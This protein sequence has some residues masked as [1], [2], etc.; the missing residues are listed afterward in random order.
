[1]TASTNAKT[2]P[3]P[4]S[5]VSRLLWDIWNT[6][7]LQLMIIPGLIY[8]I[9][10]KYIPIYG[11][12]IAFKDYKVVRG[13]AG[14]PWVGFK[15]FLTFFNGPYFVRLVRNTLL[16]NVYSLVFTFPL[17]VI[18]ALLLNEVRPL[19]F[20]KFVQTVSYLPHFISLAAVIGMLVMF[21][22]PGT[23][24]VNKIMTA[25]GG[26]VIYFMAEP[27]WFRSLYVIS[28]VWIGLGWSA[29]IYIAALAGVDVE[30][31]E[32]ASIDGATRVKL[33]WHVSLPS[34]K[35]TVVVMLILRI[36]Q[37]MSLGA[38]KVLLMY[39]ELTFDTADVISTFV[40]RRGL[41]YAEYSFSTA[42]DVFNS[43][44]NI[45]L[46]VTANSLSRKYADSS[47]W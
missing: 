20:K 9:I 24:I 32:A 26:D 33:M 1:M 38:E 23:G 11:V 44:I 4:K 46:L 10:F 40:Y 34:I 2:V 41:Q 45:I 39:N 13:I 19:I 42:V 12:T 7:Y 27:R 43:I 18:F 37:M 14:S 31:Y 3:R 29:I 21:V 28:G 16:L 6:R 17:P 47:L 15:H 30:L 36:G 35:N 5:R 25:L 8:F 22:S